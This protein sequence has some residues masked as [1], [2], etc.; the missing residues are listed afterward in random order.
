[1]GT[2]YQAVST[3]QI[4]LILYHRQVHIKLINANN[5]AGTGMPG[6][7]R[8]FRARRRFRRR[9]P[10]FLRA[11]TR[12]HHVNIVDDRITG[13]AS[14]NFTLLRTPATLD[15][16]PDHSIVSNGTTIAECAENSR[17]VKT[18][19]KIELAADAITD[20]FTVSVILWKD[21]IHGQVTQPTV[22]AV[23]SPATTQALATTKQHI[24]QFERFMFTS[25]GDKRV[26]HLRI[27]RRLRQLRHG[28]SIQLLVNST[29]ATDTLSTTTGRI[30]TSGA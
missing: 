3:G 11:V 8:M 16:D 12:S 6:F 5:H 19:L 14:A 4:N 20:P 27:P 13:A 15:E 29:G 17:I 24:C 2:I 7:R 22:A 28:E 1:M 9:G 18:D 26:I 21:G 25:Q 10:R 30:W 23:L